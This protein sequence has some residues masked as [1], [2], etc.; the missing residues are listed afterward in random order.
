MF[1]ANN[2]DTRMNPKT[3]FNTF[4]SA[5]VVDFEY[6]FVYWVLIYWE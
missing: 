6:V 2:K 5:S 4:F 1:K 3:L